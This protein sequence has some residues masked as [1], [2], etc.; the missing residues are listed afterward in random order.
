MKG[1]AGYS[2]NCAK[3][4]AFNKELQA[5]LGF[6][7]GKIHAIKRLVCRF[8]EGDKTGG[9]VVSL[10][11]LAIFAALSGRILAVMTL[12]C[13]LAFFLAM[14]HNV[15]VGDQREQSRLIFNKGSGVTSTWAFNS[16]SFNQL[17]TRFIIYII[18]P[19]KKNQKKR[20]RPFKEADRLR[21][22]PLLVML[23]PSEKE[24]FKEAADLAGVSLSSWVR[25]RLRLIA[26]RELEEAARPIAFLR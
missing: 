12:H 8:Y 18:N 26:V 2:F 11:A 13:E 7:E 21:N 16:L 9:A 5:L 17:Q 23:E 19:M 6:V 1:N 25:E 24:A 20:G 3:R 4:A 14:A 15:F 10:V 22:D